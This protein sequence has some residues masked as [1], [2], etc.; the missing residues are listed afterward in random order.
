M[1]PPLNKYTLNLDNF[2]YENTID[3]SKLNRTIIVDVHLAMS[4]T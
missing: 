3:Q 1:A 4:Q 2:D